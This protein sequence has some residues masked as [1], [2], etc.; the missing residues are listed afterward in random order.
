[1]QALSFKAAKSQS[2]AE[3]AL[4]SLGKEIEAVAQ[5]KFD[6]ME[7]SQRREEHDQQSIRAFEQQ[8]EEIKTALSEK[9]KSSY[10]SGRWKLDL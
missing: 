1:M 3:A 2:A 5:E 10:R 6:L 8:L 4:K 7:S 9:V